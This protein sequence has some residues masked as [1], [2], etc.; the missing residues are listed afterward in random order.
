MVRPLAIIFWKRRFLCFGV[1]FVLLICTLQC[2]KS[3]QSSSYQFMI[4]EM[5]LIVFSFM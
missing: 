5:V 3:V 4:H 2:S 1:S